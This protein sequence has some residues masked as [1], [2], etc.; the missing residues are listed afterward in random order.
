MSAGN[1]GED[2]KLLR[3]HYA[4]LRREVMGDEA[5]RPRIESKRAELDALWRTIMRLESD[6]WQTGERKKR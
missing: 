2:L 3:R 6:R 4:N 5:V 1:V